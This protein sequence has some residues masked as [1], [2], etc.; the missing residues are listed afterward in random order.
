MIII[1]IISI[2]YLI[3]V[4]ICGQPSDATRRVLTRG[5]KRKRLVCGCDYFGFR[6]IAFYVMFIDLSRVWPIKTFLIGKGRKNTY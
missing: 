3:N 4:N 1:I 2:P 5:K 6:R